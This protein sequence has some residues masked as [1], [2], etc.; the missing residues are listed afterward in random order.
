MKR[1]QTRN[2]NNGNRGHDEIQ[3]LLSLNTNANIP[4]KIMEAHQARVL[5]IMSNHSVLGSR[6]MQ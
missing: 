5:S 6:T 2:P 1:C 3:K 4:L